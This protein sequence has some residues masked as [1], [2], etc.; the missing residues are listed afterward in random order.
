MLREDFLKYMKVRAGN[1]LYL[2]ERLLIELGPIVE[3]IQHQQVLPVAFELL[4]LP[5]YWCVISLWRYPPL[6]P[7]SFRLFSEPMTLLCS[8]KQ[9]SESSEQERENSSIYCSH[10]VS[11]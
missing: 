5:V 1:I 10:D 9:P 6:I 7:A 11:L 4:C 2:T 8:T 3:I